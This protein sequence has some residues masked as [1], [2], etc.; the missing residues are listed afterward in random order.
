M[1]TP[2]SVLKDVFE[3]FLKGLADDSTIEPKVIERLR[4][5]LTSGEKVDAE[6]LRRALFAEEE[7]A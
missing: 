6:A 7:I 5:T 1:Y 3:T 4:S 2:P